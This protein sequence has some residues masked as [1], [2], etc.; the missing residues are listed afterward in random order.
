[1]TS[2]FPGGPR[3]GDLG[4]DA[5]SGTGADY[6]PAADL[7]PQPGLAQL[8]AT[9]SSGP[10]GNELAG[11]QAA[12]AMFLA[13]FRPPEP[14]ATRRVRRRLW[15][16]GF[17][18]FW[19]AGIAAALVVVGGFAAAAYNQALPAPVQ[20]L[21]YDAFHIIG[22]PDAHHGH[23][24]G[25]NH[26][27]PSPHSGGHHRGRGHAAPS[28]GV[29]PTPPPSVRPST[30]PTHSA[31]TGPVVV[32][33]QAVASLVTAGTQT[34]IDVQV[35]AGGRADPGLTITLVEHSAG[36][37][38]WQVAGRETTNGRGQA[39]FT[40]PDLDTNTRFR[41]T[42]RKGDVSPVV[43]VK[44]RPTVSASLT[45]GPRGIDDYV[46]VSARYAQPGD[47]VIL[48]VMRDGGWVTLKARRLNGT[49]ATTFTVSATRQAG[50]MMQV[51][52][53]PTRFHA[54]AISNSVMVPS[55]V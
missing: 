37:P 17:S 16:P 2:E 51:V 6:G 9:L 47:V 35:T 45:L 49:D 23:A 8:I 1:M 30:K 39:T 27:S 13:N 48:Q 29:Q 18:R 20:H 31:P 41:V 38:G 22:V 10:V 55:P 42:D 54:G 44:V 4:G 5:G 3:P 32:S 40:T 12:V 34:A 19:L 36:T 7:G 43:V 21:A 15:N 28:S 53:L 25:A 50:K 14:A 26:L 24:T 46:T 52:L 33:V 11:E